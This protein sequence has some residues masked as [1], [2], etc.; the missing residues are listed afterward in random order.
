MDMSGKLKA[1]WLAAEKNRAP[2]EEEMPRLTGNEEPDELEE[3]LKGAVPGAN[4]SP[5]EREEL[6]RRGSC[7]SIIAVGGGSAMDVAKCIKAYVSMDGNGV[8]GEYLK[9]EITSHHRRVV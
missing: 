9:R 2:A 7:D 8:N 3:A 4:E 6:F 1:A 5:E